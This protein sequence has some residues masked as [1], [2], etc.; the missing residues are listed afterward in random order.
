MHVEACFSTQMVACCIHAFAHWW[1]HLTKYLRSNFIFLYCSERLVP[2]FPVFILSSFSE[3]LWFSFTFP[4]SPT[5]LLGSMPL[6]VDWTK[7]INAF[8]SCG[9][10]SKL[11]LSIWTS[12]LLLGVLGQEHSFLPG[13]GART[14]NYSW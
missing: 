4:G 1:L 13:N 8:H 11:A 10:W 12:G 9:I 7:P 2:A 14:L 6:C 5:K 3:G